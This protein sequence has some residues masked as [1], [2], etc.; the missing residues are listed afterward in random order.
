MSEGAG[1]LSQVA[2]ATT[3]SDGQV[4]GVGMIET[5]ADAAS[6]DAATVASVAALD[7]GIGVDGPNSVPNLQDGIESGGD[8][9][10]GHADDLALKPD[11]SASGIHFA[12]TAWNSRPTGSSTPFTVR[13]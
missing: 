11:G 1:E 9:P 2:V 6:G 13:I 3:I 10:I 8:L 7:A 5:D 4:F 12:E